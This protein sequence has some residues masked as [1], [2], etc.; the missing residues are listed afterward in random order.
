MV[1]HHDDEAQT[2]PETN[3]RAGKSDRRK[4]LKLVVQDYV[5]RK[6]KVSKH[7]KNFNVRK[8]STHRIKLISDNNTYK[9][10]NSATTQR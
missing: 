4:K 2:G 5:I 8:L 1:T 3:L 10:L 9:I 7:G 6:E